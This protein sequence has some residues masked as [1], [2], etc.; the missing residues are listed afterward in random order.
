[1]KFKVG[2]IVRYKFKHVGFDNKR[3]VITKIRRDSIDT[4][5]MKNVCS[6]K[7]GDCFDL[8]MSKKSFKQ[9]LI[10]WGK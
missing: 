7:N 4:N 10:E 1:M 9:R 6:C 8:V 2:D 3:V 5:I